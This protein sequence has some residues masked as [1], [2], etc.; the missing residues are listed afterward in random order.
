MK[1]LL[2]THVLLWWLSDDRRLTPDH[3]AIIADASNDLLVSAVVVAE[4]SIKASLGKLD[5]PDD[6]ENVI[7]SGGFDHLDFSTAHAAALRDLPWHHR[8][9]FDRMLVAQAHVEGIP[10]LTTDA[11]IRDYRIAVR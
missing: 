3:R 7:R 6:L 2:D 11:R 4:I 1:A 8:D 9:P 5:V 10:L